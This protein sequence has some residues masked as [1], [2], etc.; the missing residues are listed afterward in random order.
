TGTARHARVTIGR[1]RRRGRVPTAAQC[2]RDTPKS[3]VVL[4]FGPRPGDAAGAGDA[5]AQWEDWGPGRRHGRPAPRSQRKRE[6][7]A[8]F[9]AP[10]L[11]NAA[12]GG[13][14]NGRSSL[15]RVRGGSRRDE[16]GRPRDVS[17]PGSVQGRPPTDR[18]VLARVGR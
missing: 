13:R 8:V 14:Y 6:P 10:R 17:W 5:A 3:L 12:R 9:A 2:A 15:A 16:T 7:G 1:R 11:S 18:G 4:P